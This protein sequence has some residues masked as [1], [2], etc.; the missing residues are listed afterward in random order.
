MV[1]IKKLKE[2]LDKR[3][4]EED[5]YLYWYWLRFTLWLDDRAVVQFLKDV[6]WWITDGKAYWGDAVAC[7][8]KLCRHCGKKPFGK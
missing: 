5:G 2:E 6:W 8:R 7:D 1:N 3:I 4:I